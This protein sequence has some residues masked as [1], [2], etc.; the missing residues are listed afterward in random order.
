MKI[1][2]RKVYRVG[3]CIGLALTNPNGG[4]QTKFAGSLGDHSLTWEPDG[5]PSNGHHGEEYWFWE[6]PE[7]YDEPT[8]ETINHPAVEQVTWKDL[9]PEEKEK[10]EGTWLE[11][12]LKAGLP[13]LSD[14]EIWGGLG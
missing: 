3:R 8:W 4:K 6:T 14:E 1:A 10:I 9:T 12:Y 7:P 13:E 2:S 5:D 11:K